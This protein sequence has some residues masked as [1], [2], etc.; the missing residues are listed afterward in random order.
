MT[1]PIEC[2]LFDL[3]QSVNQCTD[4][5]REVAATV[6]ALINS[7]KVRLRGKFAGAMIDMSPALSDFSDET[8][9]PLLPRLPVATPHAERTNQD[10]RLAA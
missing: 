5:D 1:K 8:L 4:N 9:W 2:T 10:A 7:G 3:I 6:T